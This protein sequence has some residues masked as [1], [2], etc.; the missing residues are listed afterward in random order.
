MTSGNGH[1]LLCPGTHKGLKNQEACNSAR[2]WP[3]GYAVAQQ[4]SNMKTDDKGI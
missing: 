2:Y 1:G 4:K 3:T